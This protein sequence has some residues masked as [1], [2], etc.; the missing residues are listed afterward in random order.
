MSRS[1]KKSPVWTDHATPGT[2]WAKR[3]AAKA[4]RR[5]KEY[6]AD[7][8]MYRKI[9]NPWNITDHRTYR[10]RNEAIADWVRH[11]AYFP[12]QALA[13]ALRDWERYHVRK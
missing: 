6:I 5:Y 12:D 9:Y 4:V 13:E 10:T 2:A 8:R 3:E 11:R 7:G 1:R